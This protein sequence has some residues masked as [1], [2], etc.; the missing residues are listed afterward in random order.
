MRGQE[1]CKE[2]R[3]AK[4]GE[5][6]LSQINSRVA[7]RGTPDKQEQRRKITHQETEEI[8]KEEGKEIRCQKCSQEEHRTAKAFTGTD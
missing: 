5:E 3:F 2:V 1:I 4:I 6:V 7:S 8:G